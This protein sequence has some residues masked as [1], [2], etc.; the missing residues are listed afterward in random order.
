MIPQ[1]GIVSDDLNWG[2]VRA[3]APPSCDG[4]RPKY[5][6]GGQQMMMAYGQN[7]QAWNIGGGAYKLTLP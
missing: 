4:L 7:T 2:Y 6:C 1:L 3:A 5:T